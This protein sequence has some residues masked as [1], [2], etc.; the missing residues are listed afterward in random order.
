MN[1]LNIHT[2]QDQQHY[3]LSL[4]GSLDIQT[5]PALLHTLQP[6]FAS[7]CKSISINLK[8]TDKIDSAGVATLIEG[9]RWS[10]QHNHAFTLQHV[11]SALLALLKMY[12]LNDVFEVKHGR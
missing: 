10:Q 7:T 4:K 11:S 3:T 1:H 9:L 2:E 5:A 12:K 8:R 6:L